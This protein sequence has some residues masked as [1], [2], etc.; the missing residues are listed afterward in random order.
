MNISSNGIK[1][2]KAFEGFRAEAY[3]CPAGILTVGYGHTQSVSPGQVITENE[4]CS[5][6]QKDLKEIELTVTRNVRVSLNQSQFDALV[7]FVFNVGAGNFSRSTLLK[8]LNTGDYA[9]AAGQFLRW[10]K[11][12]GNVL[13]GLA[14]R[15]LAE[16]NMFTSGR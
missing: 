15:R 14:R 7:S 4:A 12:S 9:G 8:Q 6:L 11:A 16:K 2:I 10:N 5:L 3:L 13:P 1:L